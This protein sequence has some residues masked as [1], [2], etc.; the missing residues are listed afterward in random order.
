MAY[1]Q[2]SIVVADDPFGNTPK[3]PYLI[4]SNTDHPFH[5]EE[6]IAAGITKQPAE[7]TGATVDDVHRKLQHYLRT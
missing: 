6:Y 7:A 2:G 3:R 5:G 1:A 4:V